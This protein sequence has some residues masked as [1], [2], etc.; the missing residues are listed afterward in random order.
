[1]EE[2]A[3]LVAMQRIVGGIEIKDDL[4]GRLLMSIKEDID[5]Q[6]LDRVRVVTYLVITRRLGTA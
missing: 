6:L 3:F 5:E 1:M 2:L 4:F